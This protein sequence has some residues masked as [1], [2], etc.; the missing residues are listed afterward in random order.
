MD[1]VL[2]SVIVPCYNVQ[3]RGADVG[4]C[5]QSAISQN[6]R[7]MEIL[8]E[9]PVQ[10]HGKTYMTGHSKAYIRAAVEADDESHTKASDNKSLQA[11]EVIRVVSKDKTEGEFL[12][13][14][15]ID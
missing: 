3:T 9:E 7:P 10:I 6:V 4:I 1:E 2:V 5:V 13:C 15:R 14:E 11:N 8:L 12:I